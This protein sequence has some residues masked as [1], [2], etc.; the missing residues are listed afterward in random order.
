[1]TEA[2]AP[3]RITVEHR[4]LNAEDDIRIHQG[5]H[6]EDPHPRNYTPLSLTICEEDGTLSGG[7]LGCTVWEWLL[8]NALWVERP[9]RGKGRGK[10]LLATA[11][12]EA[13]KRGCTSAQ[14]ST[15]DW[16]QRAFYERR[17][18]TRA[19]PFSHKPTDTRQATATSTCERTLPRRMTSRTGAQHH[20][21][22][23]A[24]A[25]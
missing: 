17:G 20:R 5:I 7:L 2:T 23:P 13:W 19:T 18:Y 21:V 10:H 22:E 6:L 11:E 16:Q 25:A 4:H 1:M 15:F 24:P 3:Y 9:L 8:V 12:A 14:L